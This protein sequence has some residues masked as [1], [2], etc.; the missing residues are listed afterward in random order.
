MTERYLA[1]RFGEAPEAP[2]DPR[3]LLVLRKL[4]ERRAA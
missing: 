2:G 4:L 3:E 1:Q